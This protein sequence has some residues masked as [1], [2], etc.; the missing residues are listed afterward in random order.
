MTPVSP[1]GALGTVLVAL[2]MAALI[3]RRIGVTPVAGR[4]VSLDGMRGYLALFV[5][6]FHSALWYYYLRTGKLQP[7]PSS[8]FYHL[9]HDAVL[10]FFMITGFLFSSKLIDA[11]RYPIDWTKLFISRALRLIPLYL[12]A[13]ALMMIMVAGLS[14]FTLRERWS[15]LLEHASVWLSF[16]VFGHP[17]VNG[18]RTAAFMLG[19]NWTL[20]YE[21]FFYFSLPVL[22]LLLRRY[23]AFGYLLLSGLMVVLF[24]LWRPELGM[25]YGF[26]GGIAAA[27]LVRV[28]AIRERV[29]GLSGAMVVLA[30]LCAIP[31]FYPTTGRVV[32]L[33]LTVVFTIL[34][35][36]NSLF[37]I[38]TS[39]V[40]RTLGEMGY[41]IYLLHGALLFTTFR[42]VLGLQRAAALSITQHWLVVFADAALL[43]LICSVTF[44]YI[45]APTMGAGPQVSR[46]LKSR[47]RQLAT[48]PL[49]GAKQRPLA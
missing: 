36:G 43:V 14:H 9:G 45:E 7:P 33:M 4:F 48:S 40:S 32:V 20:P 25:L 37:G 49:A 35:C 3:M 42:L 28:P 18:D 41:S 21:W 12:F 47:L 11:D 2:G 8:L 17:D 24:A 16:S 5:F 30:C 6:I 23:A 1:I 31:W 26:C 15:A 44:H 10:L 22:G 46:W 29:T 39:A 38:L 27:F 34:A 19:D 13:F